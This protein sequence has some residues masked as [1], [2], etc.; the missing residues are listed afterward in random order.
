MDPYQ[1]LGLEFY[2]LHS[3]FIVWKADFWMNFIHE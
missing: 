1:K 2:L 3:Y